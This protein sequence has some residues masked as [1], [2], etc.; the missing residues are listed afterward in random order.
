M[1]TVAFVDGGEGTVLSERSCSATLPRVFAEYRAVIH[2]ASCSMTRERFPRS[3][4]AVILD[5][6]RPRRHIL[7][8][9]F[10]KV[11]AGEPLESIR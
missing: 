10:Y 3:K 8:E 4:L 6:A 5:W 7:T 11:L 9:S 2:I 1:P